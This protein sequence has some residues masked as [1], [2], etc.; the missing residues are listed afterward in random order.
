MV[1][2]DT[3]TF[4]PGDSA[5]MEGEGIESNSPTHKMTLKDKLQTDHCLSFRPGSE[6]R[7]SLDNQG[8][9]AWGRAKLGECQYL[10]CVSSQCTN[11]SVTADF[12]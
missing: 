3:H 2:V 6:R 8:S 12:F 9:N 1:A 4:H 5:G 7:Q 11:H 10:S